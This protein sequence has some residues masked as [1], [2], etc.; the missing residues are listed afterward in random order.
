MS[1][2]FNKLG[3]TMIAISLVLVGCKT[4]NKE[5]AEGAIEIKG[6]R[7][8]L[9]LAQTSE[10]KYRGLSHRQELCSNCGMLF[11]YAE[12]EERTF[13]MRD[14]NFPLDIIWIKNQKIVNIDRNAPTEE[15]K[16]RKRYRSGQPVDSVLEVNAGFCREHDINI[17][18][19]IKTDIQ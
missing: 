2:K 5:L 3:I 6:Q 13:V 8:K 4:E 7:I 9:E 19:K 1:I 15:Q 10:E 17:G 12:P 11:L 14:M 16:P 18:D